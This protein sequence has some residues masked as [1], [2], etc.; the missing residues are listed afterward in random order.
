VEYETIT[1]RD[2][3]S[4]LRLSHVGFGCGPRAQAM[5]GD[6]SPR[7][8]DLIRAALDA[9]VTYIDTAPLYGDGES[10]ENLGRVL[11]GLP[12]ADVVVSTKVELQDARDAEGVR[13]SLHASLR[14]LRRDRL[15]IVLLH[16]R[17]I[18]PG[19]AGERP[20]HAP[21]PDWTAA[22]VLDS[23]GLLETLSGA[24]NAGEVGLIGITGYGSD[25]EAVAQ[26]LADCEH[27]D[28]VTVEYH[29]MNPSANLRGVASVGS[30]DYGAMVRAA[31]RHAASVVALRPLAGAV[32][33][34]PEQADEPPASVVRELAGKYSCSMAEIAWRFAGT[35][36]GP[37]VIL[38]GF[39]HTGDLTQA[40][41][42]FEANS[43]AADAVDELLAR[44][45]HLTRPRAARED[46]Q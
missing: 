13:A 21:G 2:G 30:R 31:K 3:R 19:W 15:D 5:V 41:R 26:V 43:P 7:Q 24:R 20:S 33:A 9:G 8:H 40:L 16:N 25:P 14:R 23:G 27:V 12:G 42:A 29:V 1:L 6:G 4:R 32:L 35:T 38:G 45:P 36:D 39:R 10:E 28:L 34:R 46:A 17:V 22:E 37:P 44:L 18:N 11:Q